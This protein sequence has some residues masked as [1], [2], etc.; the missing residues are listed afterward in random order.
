MKKEFYEKISAF[1]KKH[2]SL[3]SAAVVL[4][5]SITFAIYLFYPVFLGLLYLQHSSFLL[6]AVLVPAVSFIVLSVVRRIINA[7]RPYEK[8][9]IPALYSKNKKRCSF[10]SRHTFSA[11]IIAFTVLYVSLPLGIALLFLSTTLAVL[12][13]VCGVHFIKDVLAGFLFAVISALI[14]YIII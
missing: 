11:F 7:E 1:M 3:S 12:R 9:D 4:S 6:P 14:G 10:P 8:F 2:G 13:V 5:K